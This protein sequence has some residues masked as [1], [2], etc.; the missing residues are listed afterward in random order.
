MVASLSI[1]APIAVGAAV[2]V[3]IGGQAVERK[4]F[5]CS[6]IDQGPVAIRVDRQGFEIASG[7]KLLQTVRIGA[8]VMFVP[9]QGDDGE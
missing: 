4:T 7:D 6:P 8:F 2:I 9:E 3:E 1:P 5:V